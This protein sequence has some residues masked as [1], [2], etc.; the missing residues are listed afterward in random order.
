MKICVSNNSLKYHLTPSEVEAFAHDGLYK[1]KV[2]FGDDNLTYVIQRTAETKI[3]VSFKN[4]IIALIIPEKIADEWTATDK[5]S[6]EAVQ[7]DMHLSVEKDFDSPDV[8]NEN[9][10]TSFI[11][12]MVA[13]SQEQDN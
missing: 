7:D 3:S 11:N 1:E 5:V 8:V 13:E 12:P 9:H 4:N 6:F 2:Q 10:A